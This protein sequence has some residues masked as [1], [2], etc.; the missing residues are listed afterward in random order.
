MTGRSS[1]LQG[2]LGR[3]TGDIYSAVKESSIPTAAQQH[4]E[5]A[6]FQ[7]VGLHSNPPRSWCCWMAFAGPFGYSA[8]LMLAARMTLPWQEASGSFAPEKS[9]IALPF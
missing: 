5:R 1:A 6:S 4:D 9:P 3:A 7:L 2:L 8:A